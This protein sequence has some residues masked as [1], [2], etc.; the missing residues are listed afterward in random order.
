MTYQVSE[1]TWEC[2]EC[3]ET[4]FEIGLDAKNKKYVICSNCG[5]MDTQANAEELLKEAE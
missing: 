5:K 4:T 1:Y 2:Q 3:W